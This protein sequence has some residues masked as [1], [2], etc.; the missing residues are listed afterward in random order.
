[1]LSE[2]YRLIPTVGSD[3]HGP[4]T[5]REAVGCMEVGPD[6]YERLMKRL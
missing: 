5:G 2:A 4:K 6:V 1:M 3:F